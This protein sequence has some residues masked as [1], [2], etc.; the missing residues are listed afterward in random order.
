MIKK[1]RKE[2][3]EKVVE[4][5][6]ADYARTI[7]KYSYEAI[8]EIDYWQ[9]VN[10]INKGGVSVVDFVLEVL[11]DYLDDYDLSREEREYCREYFWDDRLYLFDV[12]FENYDDD[13]DEDEEEN[14]DEEDEG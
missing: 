12:F 1:S 7:Y 3:L 4:E 10:N 6:V 5:I 8:G 13:E 2:Y 11:D 14:E 9:E